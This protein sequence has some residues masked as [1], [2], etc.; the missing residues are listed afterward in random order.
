MPKKSLRTSE[1]FVD[2]ERFD[3]VLLGKTYKNQPRTKKGRSIHV[4][5]PSHIHIDDF[6]K[7]RHIG[8]ADLVT[9]PLTDIPK[10][11]QLPW[12]YDNYCL[13]AAD[14]KGPLKVKRHQGSVSINGKTQSG[15]LYL[16]SPDQSHIWY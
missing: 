7:K 9:V 3:V 12:D 8:I 10:T 4:D 2:G 15:F 16:G 5:K 6:D 14:I 1:Y 13:G 11:T